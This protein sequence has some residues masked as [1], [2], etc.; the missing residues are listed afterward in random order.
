M[1][2][3]TPFRFAVQEYQ[4]TT[5]R[6]WLDTARRV[7]GLG[8]SALHV[9]DHYIGN[10][11]AE[12]APQ[13]QELAVI[14]ALAMAAAVTD[15]LKVGTRVACVDY[16]LPAVLAKEAATIDLLSDGRLELGL[17]AGWTESEY[18]QIG[19][20]FD[21]V[22]Q[23]IERLGEVVGLIRDYFSGE[24]LAVDGRHVHVRGYRG[25]PPGSHQPPIM[26][27][28]WCDPGGTPR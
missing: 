5:G 3:T 17:G 26:I 7:E 15:T 20:A 12:P 10:V 14:P 25:V 19:V 23:R 18:H 8:Y 1:S 6:E 27:G 22:G 21:P 16:H 24:E 13:R 11:S 9:A 4:A 28:G 2:A